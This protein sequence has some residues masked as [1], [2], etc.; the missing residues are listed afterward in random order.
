MKYS[1][2]DYHQYLKDSCL[3]IEIYPGKEFAA[4][5]LAEYG[6]AGAEIVSVGDVIQQDIDFVV[7]PKSVITA[8]TDYAYSKNGLIV[9]DGVEGYL[10]FV[11]KYE[12]KDFFIGVMRLLDEQKLNARLL[13]SRRYESFF[14][15]IN[16]KYENSMHIIRFQG[17]YS[18]DGDL[19][20]QIVPLKWALPDNQDDCFS[21]MLKKLG[22]F[23]PYGKYVF[24]MK[25]ENIPAHS[26]GNITV[27]NTAKKAFESL[28]GIHWE[29][30]EKLGDSLLQESSSSGKRPKDILVERFGEQYLNIEN[31]PVR[32]IELRNDE[33]WG[34]Y[35]WMLKGRIPMDSYLYR[36]MAMSGSPDDFIENYVVNTAKEYM[37]S[38]N[39]GTLAKERA[40][41]LKKLNTIEPLVAKFVTET[42]DKV[43]SVPF[44]NCGLEVETQGIIKRAALYDVELGLPKEFDEADPMI[45]YYL[46]LNF[47][48]GYQRIS[49]YFNKLRCLRLKDSVSEEFA[50]EAYFAEVPVGIEKR[51]A[52]LS[53]YDDGE[54]ALLVVDGLGAEFLPLLINVAT[55]NNIYVEEMK[56][57]SVNLPTSTAF[58]EIRWN[59]AHRLRDVKQADNISHNGHSKYEKCEYEENLAE[60]FAVF[61]KS[62]LTRVVGGLKNHKRV[63]VTADHGSSYLA[64]TAYKANLSKTIPWENP[65]D[66]RYTLVQVDQNAPEGLEPAY[67]SELGKTYFVVKGYNRLPRQGGKLYGLHGGATLEERLVPFVVFTNKKPIVVKQELNEKMEDQLIENSDFD[68]L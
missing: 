14:L 32:L 6:E 51:D 68:I 11:D 66:W 19:E 1:L 4:Q 24:S 5:L 50:K 10:S 46:C 55:H 67:H 41:V 25:D 39:A 35:L 23:D 65:D 8:I 49:A 31:A 9:F 52:V 20:I 21:S 61:K 62:I 54:T 17:S 2:N 63:V 22:D 36:V 45:S 37:R 42:D 29:F 18:E 16:P 13:V 43:E 40:T 58:N 15:G 30:D 38:D 47:D 64:V 33:M 60:L 34:L 48:Y 12:Q 7:S 44:L 56:V 27:L 28:Y 26:Y 59:E 3:R 57:V 53:K